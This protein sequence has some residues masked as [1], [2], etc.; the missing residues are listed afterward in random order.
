M[1]IRILLFFLV[2]LGCGCTS[3]DE[4]HLRELMNDLEVKTSNGASPNVV[5]IIPGNGCESCIDDATNNI[6]VSNDTAY[7][8]VCN[9]E[10]DFFLLTEG[11]KVSSFNNLYLDKQK[12]SAGFN[13]VQSYPMVYFF[14]AGKYVSKEPYKPVKKKISQQKY[15][16]IEV[17]KQSI[18][19]GNIDMNGCYIDSIKITNQG[20]TNLSFSEIQTSC[21][22]TQ[23]KIGKEL[24]VPSGAT[25]LSITF[26]PEEKGEFERYVY[27]YC[28]TKDAPIEISIKG[29][30][31]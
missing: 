18:D 22:C 13:L 12:K 27:V 6:S 28:N 5:I 1:I 7:I 21:E 2:V 30:V 24:V 19:F 11:K 29:C 25:W 26:Q 15:T 16:S 31:K 23:A 4:R 14:K 8:F 17:E 20:E 9:S 10:K 3:S